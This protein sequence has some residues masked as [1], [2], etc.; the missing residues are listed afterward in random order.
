MML[1]ADALKHVSD[2][3]KQAGR[4]QVVSATLFARQGG[5]LERML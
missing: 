2:V 4:D 1:P 5:G 3:M